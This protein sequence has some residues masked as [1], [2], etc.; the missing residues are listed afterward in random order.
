MN[1]IFAEIN[2]EEAEKEKQLQD[3]PTELP[4]AFQVLT[5]NKLH[6]GSIHEEIVDTFMVD[7]VKGII[8]IEKAK[9]KAKKMKQV[10]PDKTY[11]VVGI[12]K[13]IEATY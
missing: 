9:S 12:Y 5:T 10:F 8:P 13:R 7:K 3:V 4:E 11:F 6:N 2:K 1:S